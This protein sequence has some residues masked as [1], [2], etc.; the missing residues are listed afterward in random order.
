MLPGSG[1]QPVTLTKQY[2]SPGGCEYCRTGTGEGPGKHGKCEK[3]TEPGTYKAII[4]GK[5]DYMGYRMITF[6]IRPAEGK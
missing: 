1:K 4:F 2:S 3:Y 6:E 5:G